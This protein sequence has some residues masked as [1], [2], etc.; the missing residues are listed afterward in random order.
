MTKCPVGFEASMA[1]DQDLV[2]DQMEDAE[3]SERR[4]SWYP[5]S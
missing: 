4:Q 3:G 2:Q 1:S 5:D